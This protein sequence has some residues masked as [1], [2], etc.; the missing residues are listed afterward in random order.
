MSESTDVR[1]SDEVLI[2]GGGPS[3][4]IL[5]YELL[6]RK[7]P[8]RIIEK[9]EGP[10]HTARA[11]T[12]HAR[13]MEM[14]DHMS[15]SYR[16]K[17]VCLECPG[18]IYNFPGI[19]PEKCPKN[20][21]RGLP[22]RYPFYYKISQNS[23]EQVLRNH[24][25]ATHGVLPEYSTRLLGLSSPEEAE[26][27][28]R[29]TATIQLPDGKTEKVSYPWVVGCDGAK[30]F[31][32][33]AAGIDFPGRYVTSMALMDVHLTNVNFDTTWL[34][35]FFNKN[36][37]MNISRMPGK[38]LYRVY[39]CEPTGEL[40][41]REDRQQAF[42]EVAD[43]LGIGFKVGEVEWSTSWKVNNNIAAKYRAG[44]L[45]ICGD[46][47][48]VHSPAGGQGMN[49]CMQDAFNLGWKLAAVVKGQASP[50][51]LDTYEQERKPIGEQISAGAAATHKIVMG[52]GVEPADRLALTQAPN[53]EEKTVF[54]VSG[55]SHNYVETVTPLLPLMYQN[56]PVPGPKPGARAPDALLTVSPQRHVYDVYRR[57]QFTLLVVPDLSP[58]R[59]PA[60]IAEAVRMRAAITE[61][62]PDHVCVYLI[63][64][65][66][67]EE[68]G[69]DNQ[70]LNEVGELRDRY[71]IEKDGE[72]E[73]RLVLVRPD[74]YIALAC[75][76]PR[77]EGILEYLAGWFSEAK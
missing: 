22:T 50:D 15:I 60:Q 57:P 14:F 24:L 45:L 28:G 75:E 44:R 68:F 66:R 76:L 65:R 16:L 33:G 26:D 31:V 37:F 7:V 67:E 3:G 9:R 8:V 52:F 36:L 39:M 20:D 4:L 70:S 59:K 19:P 35:Y 38:E 46:A 63:S 27:N 69:F 58:D 40:V 49:G 34:H 41:S 32:R 43:K 29:A 56:N 53:W 72:G 47:S 55:L 48:H 11:F 23:F 13:T 12:V 62:F 77:W 6:R 61:R 5:C 73:G 2:V 71:S 54:L 30:S 64:D 74:L 17:E 51:I 18:N 25:L 10:S 42:Q 1:H 21:Y